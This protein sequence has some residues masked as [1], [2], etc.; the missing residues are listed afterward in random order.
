MSSVSIPASFVIDFFSTYQKDFVTDTCALGD[1]WESPNVV[2]KA[3][4]VFMV[5]VEYHY[6]ADVS[7]MDRDQLVGDIK[8]ILIREKMTLCVPAL[9]PISDCICVRH[10]RH[11][12]AHA[13]SRI[14]VRVCATRHQ[15][16]NLH[17]Y[18]EEYDQACFR[19]CSSA[20]DNAC[21]SICK[22]DCIRMYVHTMTKASEIITMLT[23]R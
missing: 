23:E 13:K 18:F 14:M 15:Q 2:E 22:A 19:E 6:S 16:L 7:A 11:K 5:R 4:S 8:K 17:S 9:P 10:L 21:G 1:A 12:L 20:V 3:M